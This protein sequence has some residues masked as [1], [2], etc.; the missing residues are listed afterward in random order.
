MKKRSCLHR[1]FGNFQGNLRRQMERRRY[2]ARTSP[3]RL[4]QLR[5]LEISL[6]GIAVRLHQLAQSSSDFTQPM[7]HALLP[8]ETGSH[9]SQRG[10]QGAHQSR[11]RPA[12]RI[13][14]RRGHRA[15]KII[16]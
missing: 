3:I 15:Q 14:C 12:G 2:S 10:R 13:R 6:V 8:A 9:D 1:L 5:G 7:F 4:G 16:E 11:N